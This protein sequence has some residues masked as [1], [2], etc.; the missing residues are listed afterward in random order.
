MNRLNEILARKKE[1]RTA[2]DGEEKVDFEKLNAEID[3]LD[4]EQRSIEKRQEVA[5]RLNNENLEGRKIVTPEN[6]EKNQRGGNKNVMQMRWSEAVESPEYRSAWS[7]EMMGNKLTN[8][9]REL[10]DHVNTEYR[11]DFTHTTENSEVL[12]PKT[13]ADG[14]WKQAEEVSA[15]WAAVRKLRVRGNLTLITGEKSDNARFYDE[16]TKVETDELKFGELNLTGHELAK[17]VAVSWKLKKMSVEE[18]VNYIVTEIGTRMGE[19]LSYSVYEGKGNA[20]TDG[21]KPEPT[22]IKTALLAETDTPRVLDAATA[23]ELV[24]TD[25]TGLRAAVKSVYAPGSTI[26]ANSLTVWNV[27]ANI[28]DGVG[29]PLFMADAMNGG[30][31]RILGVSVVEDAGIP[32]GEI[33][34][35]NLQQ[36]YTANINEDIT[37]YTEDHVRERITDYMG[38]AIVDGAPKD[39]EA[40]AILRVGEAPVA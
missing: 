26:Y 24:Y 14:I 19:A 3:E 29:R 2:L 30:V 12:I 16:N 20:P 5:N 31:G 18:F 23:G 27:L 39:T 35:G 10:M 25:L 15:L 7:K 34:V 9:E 28:V 37:M 22:G 1:I 33:L 32:E 38:Y 6:D 13:I 36:G 4:K 11:A 8:E 17:A 40:F 21:S